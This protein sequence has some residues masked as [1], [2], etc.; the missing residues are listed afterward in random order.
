MTETS[1][2]ELVEQIKEAMDGD[3]RLF[4]ELVVRHQQRV[5]ANCRY[6]TRSPDDAE[7]LA[8]EVFTKAFFALPKFEARSSFKTWL[9][10]IKINHCLNYNQKQKGKIHVDVDEPAIWSEE[11]L[12]VAPK[13]IDRLKTMTQ[14]ERLA[15]ILDNMNDT[16]RVP[17]VLREVDGYSYQ[18]I[19]E[20]LGVGL[21]AVK[22]RIKRART[23]FRE[24]WDELDEQIGSV[25]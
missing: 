14:R 2:E 3:T 10:R 21:S 23:A 20:Q 7:D 8:Q 25:R 1:D 19:S 15:Y 16:L 24:Q 17:L 6:L 12:Q 4:G 22:M 18:E 9:Q 13:A 5:L 11:E